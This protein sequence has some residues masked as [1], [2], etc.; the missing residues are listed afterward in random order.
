VSATPTASARRRPSELTLRWLSAAVLVPFL[1]AVTIRGGLWFVAVVA[2]INAIGVNEF[3][4][5]IRAKGA[6]AQRV[7][8]TLAAALLPAIVYFGDAQLAT[9][10]LTAVLLATLL[11]QLARQRIDQA[12]ASIAATFFGVFYVGWLLSHT[13]S[14]RFLSSDPRFAGAALPDEAGIFFMI[15]AICAILGSDAGAFFVGRWFGRHKLAPAVSPGKTVEGAFGGIACGALLGVLC[16]LVFTLWVPG[17]PSASFSYVA[18]GA[19]GAAVAAIS[20]LGDLIESLLKRDAQLK[21]AGHIIPGVGG[22][23]DRFDSALLAFPLMY[24]LLVAYY[25]LGSP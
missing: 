3:Y 23:L 9:S 22:A 13:V 25:R 11:L 4:N 17:N 5:F 2:V 16:K 20:V 24:Y 18:A 19:I 21:D 14:V 10:F 15:F 12:I 1:L 8:G 7:F 6:E